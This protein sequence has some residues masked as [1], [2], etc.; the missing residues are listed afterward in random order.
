MSGRRRYEG[1]SVTVSPLDDCASA[2]EPRLP[3]VGLPCHGVGGVFPRL[4][5][6][7]ASGTLHRRFFD[8]IL[9]LPLHMIL[10][11]LLGMFLLTAATTFAQGAEA[12]P[13]IASMITPVADAAIGRG[14][15]WLVDHQQDDGSFGSGAYR[16][17]VAV[18]GLAGMALLASGSTPGRG[19]HGAA[20]DRA[21]DYLLARADTGGYLIDRPSAGHGPMY[22]HG[23]ATLFL[24]ECHGMSRRADLREK[25]ALATQLIVNSQNADGGWR[26]YP[27]RADAD[28]SVTVCQVMALR[29]ARNAGI[30]VPKETIDRSIEYVKRSQNADGG[31][32]YMLQGG[33]SAFP[34]SAAGVVGLFC[35]GVYEGP[36]VVK[37]LDY[38]MNF[39]PTEQSFRR[40][41]YWLYGHYYAVQ[42]MWQAGGERWN[43]WYPAIRDELVRRQMNDGSWTS[44]ISIECDTAFAC[45]ILQMPNN[46]LPIFER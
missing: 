4:D 42:A 5:R 29:A 24:A 17:N 33:E 18:T 43:R 10:G 28:I 1:P 31:F 46:C 38:L 19:P 12:Q 39:L 25:L 37:G 36:E 14:L 9:L 13:P 2:G 21:V 27:Q 44:A 15:R 32:M 40:E 16:G 23:F 20:I 6:A 7:A 22:G 11:P 41:T 8:R 35:A 45:I 30:D 26:Y 34:R 3:P